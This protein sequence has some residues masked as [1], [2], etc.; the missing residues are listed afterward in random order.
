M[1]YI[2]PPEFLQFPIR[3]TWATVHTHCTCSF[4][5]LCLLFPCATGR[6]TYLVRRLQPDTLPHIHR[7]VNCAE[8]AG[9]CF[10]GLVKNFV[11]GTWKRGPGGREGGGGWTRGGGYLLL[12][13]ADSKAGLGSG[14]VGG[15]G[16]RSLPGVG[17]GG[18]PRVGGAS[19]L[20]MR[21]ESVLIAHQWSG[22]GLRLGLELGLG[23]GLGLELGLRLG[24]GLRLLL[25]IAALL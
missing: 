16:R 17:G 8:G 4:S 11:P 2:G 15:G 10:G 14:G 20:G 23:E 13:F 12:P 24:L 18:W 25:G 6:C 3:L 7:E 5:D 1:K 9:K 22:L 21:G 19:R